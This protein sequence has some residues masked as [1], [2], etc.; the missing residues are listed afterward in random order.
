ML[1]R[2]ERAC[3][4]VSHTIWWEYFATYLGISALVLRIVHPSLQQSY[5]SG[6]DFHSWSTSIRGM[7]EPALPV[8]HVEAVK[9]QGSS[10]LLCHE[11]KKGAFPIW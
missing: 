4:S 10:C 2:V 5:V 7:K 3:R 1:N 6:H 8:S 11:K 9:Y